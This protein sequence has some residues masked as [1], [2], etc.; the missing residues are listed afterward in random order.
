MT[1]LKTVW[2][3]GKYPVPTIFST[4]SKTETIILA[5]FYLL[6]VNALNL[7]KSE[8]LLCSTKFTKSIDV[9]EKDKVK[10]GYLSKVV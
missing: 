5:T 2:K 7:F 9:I 4:L 1:L 6:S 3:R 10:S 8:K